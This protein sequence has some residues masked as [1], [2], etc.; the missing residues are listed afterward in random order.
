MGRRYVAKL[1]FQQITPPEVFF[2]R[3][4]FLSA[5]GAGI[6]AAPLA[7]C[8]S[9]R[10]SQARPQASLLD[11]PLRRPDVFPVDR[12]VAFDVPSAIARRDI[13][14]RDVA[15]SHNNF[16]EFLSGRGGPVWQ[17]CGD[18]EVEPWRIEITGECNNPMTLDLDDLFAF[19]H[20]ER[21]YHFR[22]V[23]RWAMNVP[24]SGFPLRR[25]LEQ[26]EPTAAARYVRFESAVVRDQMPGV[27]SSAWYPWPYHEGLRIDEAMNELAMIVTGVY[28]EPLL[29][30]HGSPVRII[31]PWKYGY[32]NPKSIVKIEL[33]RDEPSTFWQV[34]PHEYGFLSNVNPNVPHPRW[35][36]N[37]SYWLDTE[38]TFPTPIY[39]GYEEY[40]AD[41][42]PDEPQTMQEPLRQGH[43]AR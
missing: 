7:M 2:D 20:E 35:P 27:V 30:Q 43:I 36:Q 3:R 40:V 4:R 16:Y 34:Q 29:R 13:I 9:S 37:I 18:F 17:F 5:F 14:P 41:L 8:T 31:V 25:L 28:G 39:N 11:V 15:A 42:Y 24:W 19:D 26:V 33:I 12:N 32:K 23:E 10:A 1:P 21:T 6:L 38:E 22:C